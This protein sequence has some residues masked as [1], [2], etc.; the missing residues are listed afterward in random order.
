MALSYYSVGFEY[1]AMGDHSRAL[2]YQKKALSVYI[3]IHGEC[4]TDVATSFNNVAL[5]YEWVGDYANALNCRLKALEIAEKS[6][7]KRKVAIYSY[8]VGRTFKYM[9]R[10]DDANE[11]F[12]RSAD[13]WKDIGDDEQVKKALSEIVKN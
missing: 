1:G 2:E 11:Y 6:C 3:G 13:R 7:D 4:H 9:G 8:R 10:Y 5:E 12:R